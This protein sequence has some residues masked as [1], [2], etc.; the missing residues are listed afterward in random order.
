MRQPSR[1]FWASALPIVGGVLTLLVVWPWAEDLSAP[2]WLF[3]S[4]WAL[5]GLLLAA[6]A[7]ACHRPFGSASLGLGA[8]AVA[9]AL[10]LAG[11]LP[12]ACLAALAVVAADLLLRLA[13]ARGLATVPER[14]GL[15]RA[16]EAAGRGLLAVLGGGLLWLL[17]PRWAP[18]AVL[19]A[20][21]AAAAAGALL[22]WIALDAV[23]RR[24]RRPAQPLPWGSLLAP[25]AADLAG[26][27][28]GG[29]VV[30]TADRAGWGVAAPILAL[31]SLLALE[32]ARNGLRADRS[33][34]RASDLERLRHAG[35]RMIASPED[36]AAVAERI[37]AE[38]ATV[39]PFHWFQFEA[40]ARDGGFASWWAGADGRIAPGEPR[41][42]P[43]PPALPGVH[44]RGAWRIVERELLDD[45][46]VVAQLRLWCDPRRLEPEA[47]A[48][49]DRLLPQMT[50]SVRHSILDREARHD[51]LTGL[52]TRRVLEQRLEAA[53]ARCCEE[54]GA[55]AVVLCDLDHFKRI[56]DSHGHP[57]GDAALVAVARALEAERREPD[58][59]CRYGGEEFVLL[60][61]GTAEEE[62]L[63]VAERL[64]R[65][66][67]ELELAFEGRRIPLT[68]SA[69]VA[70][71]PQ[72][73]ASA[74]GELILFADE[75][76]YEAKRGGRNRCLLDLG[77]GRFLDPAGELHYAE[78]APPAAAPPR[79]FA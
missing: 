50:A 8:A 54:G 34:R 28:A 72:L 46:R 48:H 36:M 61:E 37:H 13:R 55:M 25:L 70:S 69:G 35:D 1:S 62:A 75:A 57:A 32:A 17:L 31:W 51:P 14:R 2:P 9:P 6:A 3:P 39:V 22:L 65:R 42:D 21:I 12:A 77:Q 74:P 40:L 33:G 27:A 5:A 47:L 78:D 30:S 18:G 15:L 68:L 71:F 59:C 24:L 66:V 49:L 38:C 52:A 44:R 4:P 53:H 43:H 26:W 7:G 19:P 20:R 45:R 56:N 41:P 10:A 16:F 64:R 76:L 29:A 79:I 60:L 23:E 73:W 11:P 63:A 67:E 58:L